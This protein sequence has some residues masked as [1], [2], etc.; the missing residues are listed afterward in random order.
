VV[1]AN[2]FKP[3]ASRDRPLIVS[4]GLGAVGYYFRPEQSEDA[5]QAVAAIHPPSGMRADPKHFP[6][7]Q[8][9]DVMPIGIHAVRWIAA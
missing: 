8:D 7:N 3:D 5:A 9:H 4:G 6:L 2:P 1:E